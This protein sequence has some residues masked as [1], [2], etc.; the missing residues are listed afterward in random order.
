MERRMIGIRLE[1][2]VLFVCELLN[3]RGKLV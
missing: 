1:E 3:V 2:L